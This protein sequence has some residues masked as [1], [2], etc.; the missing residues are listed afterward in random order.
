MTAYVRLNASGAIERHLE[1]TPEQYAALEVNGKAVWLRLWIVDARP[2]PTSTQVVIDAGIVI[3]ATE[4]HQTWTVREK[5]AAELEAD[6]VAA[7][8]AKADEILADLSTQRA[9]T[10]TTWDAYTA[11][12]LRAEQWRDRQALLRA[13]HFLIR[14]AKLQ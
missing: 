8:L 7:E 2:V 6:S 11:T 12:Q 14:R 5:T 4:A 1:L 13:A 3:T 10:R 9:V